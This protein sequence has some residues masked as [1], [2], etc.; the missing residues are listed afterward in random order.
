MRNSFLIVVLAVVFLGACSHDETKPLPIPSIHGEL[1]SA[2]TTK[3]GTVEMKTEKPSYSSSQDEITLVVHN[4]GPASLSFGVAYTVEKREQD[5]WYEVPFKENIAFAEV[6]LVLKPGD[7]Y[8]QKI[9]VKAFAY[10][11]TKGEY[12][13]IKR[14]YAHEKEITLA[15]HFTME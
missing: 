10:P 9:N 2:M 4:P 11:F 5:K 14:F 3:E 12:R 8:Q 13:V 6:G 7:T 15:A 1:P